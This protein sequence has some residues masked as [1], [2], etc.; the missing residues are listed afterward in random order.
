MENLMYELGDADL[1]A[2]AGGDGMELGPYN[3]EPILPQDD[4]E[5]PRF[6][7]SATYNG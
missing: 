4:V 2:V 3:G 5:T 7:E 6:R 1:A